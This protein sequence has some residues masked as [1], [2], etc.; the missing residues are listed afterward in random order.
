MSDIVDELRDLAASPSKRAIIARAAD[1]IEALR[2]LI[3][4]SVPDERP[5][6][7]TDGQWARIQSLKR[8]AQR[9]SRLAR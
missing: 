4:A 5:A 1:E 2:G 7:I 6:F 9:R 8:E 3:A